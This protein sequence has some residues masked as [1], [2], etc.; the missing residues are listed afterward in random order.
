MGNGYPSSFC[1][2]PQVQ[3][4]AARA[5]H[6]R[7]SGTTFFGVTAI[8][9]GGRFAA[10]MARITF[11]HIVLLAIAVGV[12][13]LLSDSHWRA[14]K[15]NLGSIEN[16]KK[17][18][19]KFTRDHYDKERQVATANLI[20]SSLDREEGAQGA[21]AQGARRLQPDDVRTAAVKREPVA[22]LQRTFVD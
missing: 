5:P 16:I 15:H 9:F 6:A 19:V 8:F 2:H 20:E 21:E 3:N 22:T 18:Y 14:I 7:T 13:F 12:Q 11:G 17:L 4:T 10:I 1:C